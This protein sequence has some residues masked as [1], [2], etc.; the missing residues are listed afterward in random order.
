K[1]GFSTP[2]SPSAFVSAYP[3]GFDFGAVIGSRSGESREGFGRYWESRVDL[4]APVVDA[5]GRT[6][7][8][9]R[10]TLGWASSRRQLLVG[11][12]YRDRRERLRSISGANLRGF[13]RCSVKDGITQELFGRPRRSL[14]PK[15]LAEPL[16]MSRVV[17]CHLVPAWPVAG[18]GIDDQTGGHVHFLQ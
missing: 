13:V 8:S 3:R 11:A 9:H 16:Q 10:S 12:R 6:A 17:E 1:G 5:L 14:P 4:P 15:V 18:V 7:R 2:S